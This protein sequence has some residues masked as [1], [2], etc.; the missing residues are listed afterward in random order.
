MNH[1]SFLSIYYWITSDIHIFIVNHFTKLTG[2]HLQYV[3]KRSYVKLL[4]SCNLQGLS[5]VLVGKFKG[6]YLIQ[7][8][9]Y[10][11]I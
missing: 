8:T 6:S 4:V 5:V 7:H 10:K 11:D 2:L 9:A 1:E 3:G